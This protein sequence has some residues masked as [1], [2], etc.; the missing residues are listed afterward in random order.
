M[1]YSYFSHP[2]NVCLSYYQHFRFSLKLSTMLFVASVRA[3]IHAIFPNYFITSSSVLSENLRKELESVGC[4]IKEHDTQY[5]YFKDKTYP[6]N[7]YPTDLTRIN[8]D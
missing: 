7:L 8:S 5:Y 4:D 3:F 2:N 1:I 6:D